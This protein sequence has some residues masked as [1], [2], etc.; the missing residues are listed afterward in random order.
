MLP[1]K[2][3]H[4]G[5]AV[6]SV[7]H[8]GDVYEAY[9]SWVVHES[10]GPDELARPALA[11]VERIVEM[12]LSPDSPRVVYMQFI[13][14]PYLRLELS[15]ANIACISMKEVESSCTQDELLMLETQAITPL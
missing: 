2:C 10:L 4:S 1:P 13:H 11:K 7:D 12:E 5:L 15:S 14:D 6:E 3:D 9:S 8:L